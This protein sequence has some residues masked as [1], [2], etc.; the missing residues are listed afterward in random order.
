MLSQ[1]YDYLENELRQIVDELKEE[2]ELL[3]VARNQINELSSQKESLIGERGKSDTFSQK[4][5]IQSKI[6]VLNN[7]IANYEALV[8]QYLSALISTKT[9]W[10]ETLKK[11]DGL[12]KSFNDQDILAQVNK[13]KQLLQNIS[14]DQFLTFTFDSLNQIHVIFSHYPINRQ[15]KSKLLPFR[16]SPF[17]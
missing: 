4:E 15:K 11:A 1:R 8:D 12:F 7:K 6:D 10:L 9:Q 14:E 5:N 2:T 13:L 16:I 3:N 17:I